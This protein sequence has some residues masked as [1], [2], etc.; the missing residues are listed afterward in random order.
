MSDRDK[1]IRIVDDGN[2]E[3]VGRYTTDSNLELQ[4]DDRTQ[5]AS[6]G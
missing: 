3:E 4:L 1:A 2:G 6:D 5:K